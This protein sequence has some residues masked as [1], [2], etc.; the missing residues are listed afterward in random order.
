MYVDLPMTDAITDGNLVTA[1][2]PALNSWLAKF[3]VVSHQDRS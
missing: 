3:L 2:R 1:R